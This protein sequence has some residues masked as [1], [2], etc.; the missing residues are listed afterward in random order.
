MGRL[1]ADGICGRGEP[2]GTLRP[3]GSLLAENVAQ[4]L[5]DM[6]LGLE[7]IHECGFMHLDFK[8][9]NVLVTRR[10]EVR[11]VDFDTAQPLPAQP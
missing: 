2:Q 1:S 3:P 4:L 11:L 9:E 5:I 8:P 6:A 7:H 10:A